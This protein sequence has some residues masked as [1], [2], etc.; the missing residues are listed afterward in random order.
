MTARTKKVGYAFW[1]FMADE[2]WRDGKKFSSPDGSTL[3]SFS[4]VN[5]F[6][7]AGYDVYRLM[8]NRDKEYVD[9]NGAEAFASFSQ[10]QRWYAYKKLK[11][12]D[13]V[14]GNDEI[15]VAFPDL[16]IVILEWRMPTL[17][18]VLPINTINYDPDLYIQEMILSHYKKLGV[19][20]IIIDL[21]Y[22]MVANDDNRGDFVLEL[23]Y[24]RGDDHH[25][26]IPFDI[27]TI[28]QIPHEL[29]DN[30][31]VYVGNRYERDEAFNDFFGTDYGRILNIQYHVHGN[32]IEGNKDSKKRWPHVFF[33]GRAQPNELKEAYKNSL[34]TPLLLKDE[35][36]E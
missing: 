3:H 6:L 10:R 11:T 1:G 4:I 22:K 35:Y 17:R 24:K 8:P 28:R 2:R 16:D 19:P 30:K 26:F 5:A 29:P 9:L 20:I 25:F 23:G 15:G 34:V 18:N 33:H 12:L 27:G 7:D 13:F 32:W 36:N 14:F 31:I 21:D